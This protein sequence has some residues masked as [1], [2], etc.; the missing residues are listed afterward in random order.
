[1]VVTKVIVGKGILSALK[2]KNV[3][4]FRIHEE[5]GVGRGGEE[6]KLTI[7]LCYCVHRCS[8]FYCGYF[9]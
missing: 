7:S 4:C 1:M 6:T 3:I 8:L 5:V 2:K 9:L